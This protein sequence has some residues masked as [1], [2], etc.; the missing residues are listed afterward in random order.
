MNFILT[1]S[2]RNLLRQRRRSILLGTA[3]AFGTAILVL[4][5][6]FAHGISE[7][8]F[9]D[10]V[11]VV[12]G[13]VS[14]SFAKG[15]NTN[16]QV[17]SDGDRIRDIIKDRVPDLKRVDEAIGAFARAIGNGKAD[18]VIMVGVE[19]EPEGVLDEEDL[20]KLE[21]QFK[22]VDGSFEALGDSTIENPVGLAESK[23]K[24]LNVKYGDVL[25]VRFT[26]INGQTQAARL[27]VAM[28][29]KPA[30]VFMTAP[31]F[32]HVK[33]VKRLLG[34]GKH[35]VPQ[36]NLIVY[37][38]KKN[39]KKIADTLHA[40]LIPPLAVIDGELSING[41]INPATLLALRT[42]SASRILIDSFVQYNARL[43]IDSLNRKKSVIISSQL[44]AVLG[45][46][47]GDTCGFT[48]HGKFPGESGT[49]KMIVSAVAEKGCGVDG[50][51]VLVNEQLFY[52]T[53][54]DVWPKSE[55]DSSG[56]FRPD[57]A[58]DYYAALGG[59]WLLLPRS[60][61]TK[62]VVK[63]YRE[64]AQKG[65]KAVVVSV[66]S[67]YETASMVLNLEYAL[68]LIT[69]ICVLLL[70]FIILIGVINTLRMTIRERTREIGTVRA[71]GMQ[72][73]DVRNSYMVETGLLAFFS[74]ITGT[75]I[76]FFAMWGLSGIKIDAGENPLS[77]ILVDGHLFF[78]PTVSAVL[79]FVILIVGIALVTAFFPARR[80]ARLSAADALRHFE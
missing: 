17:F 62:D 69:F 48:Y 64:I 25:R 2:F 18:N 46:E 65:W 14:I 51:V 54:Y 45:I 68:N 63:Q 16:N 35:D 13:H 12:A 56:P 26:D 19:T 38:P 7:V 55:V 76:A 32:L 30:N 4:A 9:N 71:I 27:T 28:V 20:K 77:M 24:S 10:I 5:N 53:F 40:G 52:N 79:F 21:Q 75:I 43:E 8:L 49:L 80:A 72:Q 47:P 29:F 33:N 42:D 70:F 58:I 41:K 15:G 3:I 59:E 57:T 31:I 50:N 66:G 67:M 73:S 22:I 36:L 6:A 23:A 11:S 39:A 1:I 34:Y 78:A 61:T 37:N 60:N 44:A 74:A